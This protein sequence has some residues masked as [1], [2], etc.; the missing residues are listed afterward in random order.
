M[1]HQI[2]IVDREES[3]FFLKKWNH[4]KNYEHKYDQYHRK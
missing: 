2:E 3:I 4:T 1:N